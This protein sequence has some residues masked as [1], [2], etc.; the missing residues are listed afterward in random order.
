MKITQINNRYVVEITEGR[1]HIL[2]RK[3]LIWNLKNVFGIK[4]EQGKSVMRSLDETGSA[5]LELKGK[6]A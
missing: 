6:A 5:Q 1:L 2:N 3:A 4:G